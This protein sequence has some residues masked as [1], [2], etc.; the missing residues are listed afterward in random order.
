MAK[1]FSSERKK[2][3][4]SL[5]PAERDL[6]EYVQQAATGL[7]CTPRPR[8]ARSSLAASG[9]PRRG[10][11]PKPNRFSPVLGLYRPIAATR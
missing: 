2:A 7:I 10:F 5:A 11:R 1:R 4:R 3:H 9:L 8:P 6:A